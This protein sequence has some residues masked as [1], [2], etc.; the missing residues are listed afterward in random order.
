MAAPTVISGLTWSVKINGTD[1]HTLGLNVME[2][3]GMDMPPVRQEEE[4]FPGLHGTKVFGDF[5]TSR[6]FRL[7]GIV[8]GDSVAD[9]R[10]RIDNIK[11]YFATYAGVAPWKG[12]APAVLER[13]DFSDRYWEV[14]YDGEFTVTPL[15]RWRNA[16]TAQVSIGLRCA[17]PFAQG[18]TMSRTLCAGVGF[19]RIP[20]RA[21]GTVGNAIVTP[22]YNIRAAG[23]AVTNPL[24]YVGDMAFIAHFDWN[25]NY[26]NYTNPST[27]LT[28]ASTGSVDYFY[29]KYS[30]ALMTGTTFTFANV[31]A[32]SNEWSAL[33]ILRSTVAADAC[34]TEV[35]FQH[36]QSNTNNYT[37]GYNTTTNVFEFTKRANG[38][39]TVVLPSTVQ[40]FA[41]D[42]D[43]AIGLTY[44]ETNGMAIYINGVLNASDATANGKATLTSQPTTLYLQ[45]ATAG[46]SFCTCWYF[47]ELF[48]WLRELE[49]WEM[50]KYSTN[51]MLVKN[52][53]A[54]MGYTGTIQD[55]DCLLFDSEKQTLQ[56]YD[57]SGGTFT[58]A[59]SSLVGSIPAIAP[60]ATVI[61]NE[62]ALSGVV[63][64]YRKRWL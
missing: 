2:L 62:V 12:Q 33:I 37:L 60:P 14:Y 59:I 8:Y 48:I 29:N 58:N 51:P 56:F 26:S 45:D 40:T 38:K 15:G 30:G 7:T 19:F 34:V 54:K 20:I 49:D 18:T 3:S 32:A 41:A 22:V 16:V 39:T 61:S 35:L 6:Q 24:V 36:W 17:T 4:I 44:S 9:L 23:G 57:L 5:F 50:M 27:L 31:N 11:K 53:N 13:T 52:L 64:Q 46:G 10:T 47:D 55:G 1:L 43:L 63:V 25:L 28:G 42:A 21:D